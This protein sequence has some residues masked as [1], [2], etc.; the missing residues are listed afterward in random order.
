MA[1]DTSKR[2]K[3]RAFF[4]KNSYEHVAWQLN[5]VVCGIDEV[6]RGCLSGPLVTAAVILP[7]DCSYRLLKDSKVMTPDE[8][9]KADR[10]IRKNC[11]YSYGIVHHRLIDKHNIWHATLIAMRKALMNLL[12]ITPF[13][14]H[15]ILVDAMPLTLTN[16]CY[17]EIPIYHFPFGERRSSSIAAASIIAKVKRD[18]IMQH[19][20]RTFPHYGWYAN[21]GYGTDQH[22]KAIGR[23]N[24]VI[25]HR[26]SYLQNLNTETSLDIIDDIN[27]Q[28][29]I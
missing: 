6:G 11:W 4:K 25:L 19:M 21:K 8:R 22:K 10:W 27:Q 13:K 18:A 5:K 15:S 3:K 28:Q 23:H 29:C 7:P 17:Q 2:D 9:E 16:S 1:I 12:A 14:P 26:L 20:D 24:R